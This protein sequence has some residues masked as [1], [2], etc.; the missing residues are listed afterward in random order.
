MIRI[1]LLDLP[2]RKLISI[3]LIHG[4]EEDA[5]VWVDEVKA[6]FPEYVEDMHVDNCL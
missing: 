2:D 1:C 5:A 6:K 4:S 3:S